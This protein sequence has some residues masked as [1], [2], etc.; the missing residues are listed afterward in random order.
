MSEKGLWGRVRRAI[1]HLDPVRVENRVEAGT[2]DVWYSEGALELKWMRIAPKRGGIVK[3]DH[4]YTLEQRVWAIR[5]DKAGGKVYVLLK[6]GSEY[7][8]FK[9][10]VAAECLGYSTLE[11]LREKAIGKWRV[12]LNDKELGDL[13]TQK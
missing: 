13:L 9:G 3:L 1:R 4:D 6:I 12:K 2:P 11:Q 7:L 8:L 10:I 5:R